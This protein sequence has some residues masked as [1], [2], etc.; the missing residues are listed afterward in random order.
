M[1]VTTVSYDDFYPTTTEGRL[2]SQGLMVCCIALLGIVTASLSW[3]LLEKVSDTTERSRAAIARN[4]NALTDMI[5][6]LR[7]EVAAP[8]T[9][10][11]RN[12]KGRTHL[13]TKRSP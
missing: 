5:G 11:T 4:L 9:E 1:T 6:A 12:R 2:Y 13:A 7:S 3:W 8:R 10:S